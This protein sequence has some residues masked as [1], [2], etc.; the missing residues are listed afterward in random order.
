MQ[1]PSGRRAI[2]PLTAK[3]ERF[4]QLIALGEAALDAYIEAYKKGGSYDKK[5]AAHSASTLLGDTDVVLRI[6]ELK[7]PIMRKLQRKME[8]NLNKALEQCEEMYQLARAQGDTRGL[9]KAIELQGKFTKLLADQ[10]DVTH[11]YGIL[12]DASTAVLLEMRKEIEL[13]KS[14]RKLIEVN[15]GVGAE[16]GSGDTPTGPLDR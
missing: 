12:D 13:R 16:N 15:P 11:R 6:E 14:K 3:R 9:G 10:V 1:F 8:Y 2:H 5:A 7:R 4:C